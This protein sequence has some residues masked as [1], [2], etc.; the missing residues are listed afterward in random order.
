MYLFTPKKFQH[1]ISGHTWHQVRVL[2]TL[3]DFRREKLKRLENIKSRH[4]T[5][6]DLYKKIFIKHGQIVQSEE[7]FGE[8][9]FAMLS[10]YLFFTMLSNYLFSK[11]QQH[12]KETRGKWFKIRE[13]MKQQ[14][15]Q[16]I[17]AKKDTCE[18]WFLEES[19][20]AK[21]RMNDGLHGFYQH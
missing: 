17:G 21:E 11:S 15:Q 18:S 4:V 13:N 1:M 6:V 14:L 9:I 3:E 12:R 8:K 19:H 2:N 16:K 5:K 7:K 20:D 10:S